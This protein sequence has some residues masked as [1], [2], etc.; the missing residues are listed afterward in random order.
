MGREKL[1]IKLFA[2]RK[3]DELRTEAGGPSEDPKWVLVGDQLIDRSRMLLNDLGSFKGIL[4]QKE[5][6]NSVIPVIVEATLDKD[7]T[8][9]SRRKEIS[10]LFKIRN[11]N[12]VIGLKEENRLIIK[13]E[14]VEEGNI[15]EKRLLDYT[16][17]R[18]G[19]SCV[20]KLTQYSPVTNIIEDMSNYKVKLVDFQEENKNEVI[21]RLFED[22]VKE[23]KIEAKK[24]KYTDELTV[25]NL[26]NI[27]K[28]KINEFRKNEVFEAIRSIEPMPRHQIKIDF[29]QDEIDVDIELPDDNKNYVTIGI[30]DTGIADIPCLQP[31][32]VDEC[33]KAY[34]ETEIDATHGT[35]VAGI[36]VYGD[37]LEGE[38]WV[39][40][41]PFR[42][43]DATIFPDTNKEEIE[44]DD[45]IRN[46]K[47]AIKFKGNEI[48]IWNLSIGIDSTIN[49]EGFSD[50]A[51]ALDALQDKYNILICKS[52]GNCKKFLDNLPKERL[53]EGAD[54]VRALVVGSLAHEQSP[55][56]LAKKDNPSPFSRIGPGPAYIIKPE[57]VHYGG[58]TGIDF[59]GKL[60]VSGV[61][62]FSKEGSI[63]KDAGTSYATPRITALAAGIFQELDEQF[64]PLLLKALIVHSASY[65]HDLTIPNE[66]RTK[67]IGFGKPKPIK[68]IIYNNQ[69]EVTL[70]LRDVMNKGQYIDIM[71]LPMPEC[72]IKE[73]YY[74]GQITATLV[75][76]PILDE[77]QGSEYCQSNIEIK[78]GTYTE[79]SER[80]TSKRNILNPI[81]RKGA[82]NILLQD[83][84]SKRS[85][86]KRDNDFALRERLLIQYGDKYYPV[87]KYAVD[88]VELTDGNRDNYLSEDKKWF[89]WLKGFYRDHIVRKAEVEEI[90]LQQRFCLIL[91]IKDPNE[92]ALV[93]DGVSQK[94]DEYHFWHSNIKLSSD[95][96]VSNER[97]I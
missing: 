23:N 91:T 68:D 5:A 62:S 66:E 25:Y 45:L 50:F 51:I 84:Y 82:K 18:F 58:N 94:L 35:F 28:M 39:G 67:N 79:K 76:E 34:H 13:I 10:E 57:V 48:K 17:N 21:H 12:N 72:L 40:N 56:D 32:I 9:K 90:S 46:I 2:K 71:D 22:F 89:L 26:K 29:F 3:I 73:G 87:K 7:A 69:H 59:E 41:T 54:S 6:T 65:P 4:E 31:W 96:N 64:D 61:K 49:S 78:L 19:I 37:I 36:A 30:L 88:L 43:F 47:R 1:P 85:L 14:S 63:V 77:S 44:E 92:Q 8:A 15:I 11:K 27:D 60:T 95:V 86:A 70:I 52:A 55:T 74:T 80:D 24:T 33:W 20:E 38:D 97:R 42:L 75:Y 53:T 16:R 83:I 81:G 93:Y